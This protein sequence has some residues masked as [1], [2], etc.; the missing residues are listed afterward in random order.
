MVKSTRKVGRTRTGGVITQTPRTTAEA[1]TIR[2]PGESQIPTDTLDLPDKDLNV[3]R[4]GNRV[5]PGRSSKVGNRKLDIL[6]DMPDVR[7]RIYTP[8]L[9]A[10]A[11]AIRPKIAFPI[12]NQGRDSSCTGF[13]LAHVIDFLRYRNGGRGSRQ[14]VSA[15]MLYEMA[16]RN[17]EWSGSAYEGSSIRGAIKGFFRNGVCSERTARD[18]PD[19]TGAETW[20]LTYAMA[21]EARETRLG[22]YFRLEPDISD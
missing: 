5:L 7:D 21:K 16:K 20:S 6:P 14:R 19:K 11:S 2:A 15:R 4:V 12:R 18:V 13:S 22:A 9:S 3:I 1:Q 10:L 17:D 8:T